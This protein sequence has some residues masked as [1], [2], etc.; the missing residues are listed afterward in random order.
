[1]M[2]KKGFVGVIEFKSNKLYWAKVFLSLCDP[3][4]DPLAETASYRV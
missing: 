4:T 3:E 1:M 2:L